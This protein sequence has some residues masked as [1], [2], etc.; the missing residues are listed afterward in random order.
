MARDRARRRSV[1][2]GEIGR[3]ARLGGRVLA[4]EPLVH[5]RWYRAPV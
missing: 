1:V 3:P 5:R 2:G 4:V